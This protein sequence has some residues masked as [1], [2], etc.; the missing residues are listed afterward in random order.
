MATT[1]ITITNRR[2]DSETDVGSC[3]NSSILPKRVSNS[4]AHRK[5]RRLAERTADVG[6][7]QGILPEPVSS[8]TGQRKVEGTWERMADVGSNPDKS[9]GPGEEPQSPA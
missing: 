2:E 9:N 8:D 6:L 5:I 4:G 7:N 3:S 1:T